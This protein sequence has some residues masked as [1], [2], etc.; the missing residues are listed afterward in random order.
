MLKIFQLLS[1]IHQVTPEMRKC[2]HTLLDQAKAEAEKSTGKAD[3]QAMQ[4]IIGIAT[5]I[6]LY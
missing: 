2:I 6:G 3:D 1:I 5:L 4:L